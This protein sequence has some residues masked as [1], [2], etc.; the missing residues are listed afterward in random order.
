MTQDEAEQP[1]TLVIAADFRNIRASEAR[2]SIARWHSTGD[3]GQILPAFLS[4]P[5]MAEQQPDDWWRGPAPGAL[6]LLRP[7][8]GPGEA[9]AV[10]L[11]P[12]AQMCGA[13]V[14]RPARRRWLPPA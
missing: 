9:R 10:A 1:R 14:R 4:G 12:C 8:P 6:L 11:V 2:R 7:D 13:G 3:H 5:D